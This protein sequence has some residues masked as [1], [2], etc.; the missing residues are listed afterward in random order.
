MPSPAA[1]VAIPRIIVLANAR[2]QS[3]RDVRHSTYPRTA[4]LALHVEVS[5][6]VAR[7]EVGAVSGVCAHVE[8]IVRDVR[9]GKVKDTG[10][11]FCAMSNYIHT[12]VREEAGGAGSIVRSS[13]PI[14][15]QC[16]A[17][18]GPDAERRH[19]VSPMTGRH[20]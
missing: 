14:S 6:R 13:V 1:T 16:V 2:Q 9:E 3:P 4:A 8:G 15:G 5:V 17:I 19:P 18:S 7:R 20:P 11:L 10:R 12:S